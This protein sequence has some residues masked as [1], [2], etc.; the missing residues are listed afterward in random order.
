MERSQIIAKLEP[1]LRD[2]F[3]NDDIEYRDNLSAADI[4]EWD[5]LSNV[6]LMV[7]V[8]RAFSTRFS[9]AEWGSLHN[10]GELVTLLE[11]R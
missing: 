5:S 10:I 4:E 8:E 2:V 7:T 11:S 9:T 3:D 6:T 1:I